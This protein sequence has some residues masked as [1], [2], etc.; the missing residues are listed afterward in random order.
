M[1]L[2]MSKS[3]LI[4]VIIAVFNRKK[5]FR[6]A[7][8]SVLS[9]TYTNFEIIIVDD[10]S[11]DNP[12]R[13]IFSLIEKGINIKYVKH[14]NRGTPLSLNEGI[15]LASG[16]YI[17]FLDSDD[18]YMPEHLEQRVRVFKKF[19]ELDL[20][21]TTAEIYG[22]ENDMLIPD[23]RNSEKLIHIE[24]CI[25]GATIF[26]KKKV[27]ETMKG[28]RD[29]Y[30]YDYD[31]IRRCKKKFRTVKYDL[32]TYIYYRNSSDSILSKKKLLYDSK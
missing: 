13:Y 30:G 2:N 15:K 17:T 1:E 10:G 14:S 26:G 6:T 4:T 21:H 22:S 25:I 8:N 7:I 23:A 19:R 28:F 20:I 27:F 32:P 5:K 12:E 29:I 24:K 11:S 9:Q 16:K 31:F 3:P 18:R